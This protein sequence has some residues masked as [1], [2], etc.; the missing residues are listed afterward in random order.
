MLLR[1]FMQKNVGAATLKKLKA[2]FYTAV[3]ELKTCIV[4]S[5]LN[6]TTTHLVR[7]TEKVVRRVSSV[8]LSIKLKWWCPPSGAALMG[9]GM[10][11]DLHRGRQHY[12]FLFP[13]DVFWYLIKQFPIFFLPKQFIV[14]RSQRKGAMFFDC[15]RSKGGNALSL[16]SGS[17]RSAASPCLFQEFGLG[18]LPRA[19]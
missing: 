11:G 6:F 9:W 8:A 12:T 17:H 1:N 10:Y 5:M 14:R 2:S 15:H 4:V 13:S 3:K 18:C 19:G 7:C 16:P